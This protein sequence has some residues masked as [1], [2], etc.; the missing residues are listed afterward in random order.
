MAKNAKIKN[1]RGRLFSKYHKEATEK[2][3]DQNSENPETSREFRREKIAIFFGFSVIFGQNL[4][5]KCQ[6]TAQILEIA[7]F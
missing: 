4:D 5:I 1:P 3:S 6:F 2:I 7:K